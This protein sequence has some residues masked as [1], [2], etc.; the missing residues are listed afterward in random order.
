VK[1]MGK[2][3]G[4]LAAVTIAGGLAIGTAGTARAD[5]VPPTTTWAEIYDPYTSAPACL[6][7]PGGSTAINTPLE[8]WHCHGYDSQGAPQRWYFSH[9]SPIISPPDGF[10]VGVGNNPI[11]CLG[12]DGS[13][14][15]LA[16]NRVM[17]NQCF[18]GPLWDVRSRN[19]YAGDPVFQLELFHTGYC[20]ALPDL[21]GGNAEPVMLE[22]CGPGNLKAYWMFG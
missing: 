12:H 5:V 4:L 6:D 13:N 20:L 11:R 8:L 3:T 15:Q 9:A 10:Q 18:I 17:L 22:P 21:S 14:S 1:R 16:G 2:I 7:D 19:A